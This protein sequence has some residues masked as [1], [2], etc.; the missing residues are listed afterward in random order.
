MAPIPPFNL[1]QAISS[2]PYT[3]SFPTNLKRISTDV[4]NLSNGQATA[5]PSY[6][7]LVYESELVA[8]VQR[9]RN[10]TNGLVLNRV[11]GWYGKKAQVGPR[12]EGKLAELAKQYGTSVVCTKHYSK[13][14]RRLKETG[15]SRPSK[16]MRAKNLW[17]LLEVNGLFAR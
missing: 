1:Q 4:F 12:E 6:P 9:V 7:C 10:E 16:E 17:M 5:V 13:E 8:V 15:R 3:F 11:W 14:N 2:N